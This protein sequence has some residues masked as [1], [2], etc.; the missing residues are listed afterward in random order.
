M[1][2]V[3]SCAERRSEASGE[4][5]KPTRPPYEWSK[6]SR[7]AKHKPRDARLQLEPVVGAPACAAGCP[8]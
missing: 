3:G 5:R 1:V 4:G 6:A 8:R 2:T 7:D